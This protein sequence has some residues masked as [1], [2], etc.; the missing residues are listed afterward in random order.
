MA[1]QRKTSAKDFHNIQFFQDQKNARSIEDIFPTVKLITINLKTTP[2]APWMGEAKKNREV[3][4]AHEKAFFRI[5]CR[6]E[7]IAGGIDLGQIVGSLVSNRTMEISGVEYCRG[8]R[9]EDRMNVSHC[10]LQHDY[11]VVVEY[12]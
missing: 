10:F 5:R 3:Y 1:K 8:W 12:Y 11:T 9:D 7:C 6:Y 4:R 2:E